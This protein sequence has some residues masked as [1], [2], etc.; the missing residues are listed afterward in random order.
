MKNKTLM[1]FWVLCIGANLLAN[2][3]S[4]VKGSLVQKNTAI[5]FLQNFRSAI[6]KKSCEDIKKVLTIE[7]KFTPVA[8]ATILLY[9]ND[10]NFE[11]KTDKNGGFVFHHIPY[12]CYELLGIAN[13]NGKELITHKNR[14]PHDTFVRLR[15]NS[16]KSVTVVGKVVN[17]DGKPQANINVKAQLEDKHNQYSDSL[18]E[19]WTTKTDSQGEFTLR[20]IPSPNLRIMTGALIRGNLSSVNSLIISVESADR[21]IKIVNI[22]PISQEILNDAREF[23]ILWEQAA[24]IWNKEHKDTKEQMVSIREKGGLSFPVSEGNRIF[25]NVVVNGKEKSHGKAINH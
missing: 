5:K 15:I 16:A 8:N 20:G 14:L 12:G 11:T 2:D 22:K 13:D 6:E 4:T 23:L 10:H 17:E 7:G 3:Y 1:V 24:L 19:T 21:I 18:V 25:L 9:D